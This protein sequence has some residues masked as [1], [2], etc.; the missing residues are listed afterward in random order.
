MNGFQ[1]GDVATTWTASATMRQVIYGGTCTL[2]SSKHSTKVTKPFSP[3][4]TFPLENRLPA[5]RGLHPSALHFNSDVQFNLDNGGK[6][7]YALG[8]FLEQSPL[9]DDSFDEL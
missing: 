2:P 6:Y 8:V 1:H 5:V 3:P 4:S 9:G 7:E